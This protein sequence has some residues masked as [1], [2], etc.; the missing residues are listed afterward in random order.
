MQCDDS[1]A[2]DELGVTSEGSF[3]DACDECGQVL[4]LGPVSEDLPLLSVLPD[5]SA[6]YEDQPG[7]DGTRM[8]MVCSPECYQKIDDRF[9]RR[10]FDREELWARQ[11]ARSVLVHGYRISPGVLQ[12]ETGLGRE[13]IEAGLA[14]MTRRQRLDPPN[15][16]SEPRHRPE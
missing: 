14:W 13:Q 5:S 11:I 9:R 1:G 2:G 16:G 15:S 7:N 12:R 8:T 3:L 10:P 6:V 4:Q